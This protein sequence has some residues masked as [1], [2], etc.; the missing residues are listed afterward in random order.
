M[1]GLVHDTR[2]INFISDIVSP[3]LYKLWF[4]IEREHHDQ[5]I[6]LT[7]FLRLQP[8]GSYTIWR[9][10]QCRKKVAEYVLSE[11]I[12]FCVSDLIVTGS[13][14]KPECHLRTIIS[15]STWLHRSEMV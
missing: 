13:R 12:C 15:K 11:I 1:E 2:G 4:G 8:M 5:K 10:I 9:E 14:F 7:S 3:I 6:Y